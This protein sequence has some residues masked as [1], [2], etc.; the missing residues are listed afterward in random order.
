MATV[1]HMDPSVSSQAAAPEEF[2]G[3]VPKRR[4]RQEQAACRDGT[5]S[6]ETEGGTEPQTRPERP[7]ASHRLAHIR[8]WCPLDLPHDTSLASSSLPATA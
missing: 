7:S 5:H 3:L 1:L 6:T 4:T 2:G 8:M